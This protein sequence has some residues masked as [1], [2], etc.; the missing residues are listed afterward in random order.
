[1]SATA[2]MIA[3]LRRMVDE[4]TEDIYDDDLMGEYIEAYPLLDI[5]GTE[6]YE[7]DYSTE[8]PTRSIDDSWID[9][10]DLHA[11]AADIWGEKAAATAENYDFSAD[12][13]NYSRSKRYDQYMAKARY[14]QSRRSA[15]TTKLVVYPKLPYE[16][17]E[18]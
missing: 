6:P 5:L 7:V 2:A 11:A 12:G 10:Y 1:M 13:G 17:E 8:P 3:R 18:E 15:K 14:H 4:P 9:T 16:N